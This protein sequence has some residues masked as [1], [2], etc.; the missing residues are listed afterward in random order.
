LQLIL[1]PLLLPIIALAAILSKPKRQEEKPA[2]LPKQPI[3]PPWLVEAR[4]KGM[5]VEQNGK[6]PGAKK[7]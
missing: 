1:L 6:L 7:A 4:A 5:I 2:R 3:E